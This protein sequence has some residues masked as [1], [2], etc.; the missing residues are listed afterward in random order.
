MTRRSSSIVIVGAGQAGGRAAEALRLAGHTG[1]LTLIGDEP[2]LPHERPSLSKDLLIK[3]DLDSITWVRPRTWYAEVGISILNGRSVTS[4]DRTRGVAML[5]DGTGISFDALMLATGARPRRLALEG[6]DH[7]LGTYLRTIEDSRRLM[8]RLSPGT[9]IAVIG[10]GFIGLEVAAAARQHGC[11]VTVLERAEQPMAR[12]VPPLIGEYFA[13]LHAENGVALRTGIHIDRMTSRHGRVAI[14]PSEGDALIA[15]AVVIGIGVVPNVELA[16]AAGL[17]VDD[18][19]LVDAYGRTEDPRIYAAGDVANQFSPLLG[20]RL[21]LESWHNAQNQA[22][23]AARNM[24]GA[25][26]PYA[27]LPWF[28]SD[29]FGVNLQIAGVPQPGDE[30]VQ[31][32]ALGHGPALTFYVRG[33]ALAA[34][35]G[36]DGGRDM[37]LA[38]EIASAGGRVAATDLANPAVKLADVWRELKQAA[39]VSAGAG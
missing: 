36:I 20:R 21:R 14:H 1:P 25:S 11:A 31:R 28:W 16:A 29:Q 15:D 23:A 13:R 24:L 37:R 7:P 22:I 3:R 38:R 17:E 9:H 10:A 12:A 8:P 27:Q 2:H 33:G 30:V 6:A 18:G 5:D 34:V 32:G 35:I 4:I 19:I 39:A 26:I